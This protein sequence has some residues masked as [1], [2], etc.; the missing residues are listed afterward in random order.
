MQYKASDQDLKFI[1]A[2]LIGV[3]IAFLYFFI[4]LRK[5][6]GKRIMAEDAIVSVRD[7]SY[8]DFMMQLPNF[9]EDY[10]RNNPGISEK[11]RLEWLHS[12]E[13]TDSQGSYS[14]ERKEQFISNYMASARVSG[15]NMYVDQK[16]PL[17]AAS[18]NIINPR[19]SGAFSGDMY[20][21]NFV[22][23]PPMNY[24]PPPAS[25]FAGPSSNYVPPPSSY[26]QKP[27]NY[28]PQPSNYAPPPSNYVPAPNNYALAPNTYAPSPINYAAPGNYPPGNYP[29]GNYPPG[30]YPPGNY[31]PGNYPPGNYPPGNYPPGNYP[32]GN[33]PPANYPPGNYPPGNYPPGNYP[34]SN[35]Y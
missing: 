34:P 16:A 7:S 33:Y 4:P 21:R 35:P 25:N 3:I 8:D 11:Q 26:A 29:P 9:T 32:P 10:M 22:N 1:I 17:E 24:A 27:S 18:Y 20:S 15:I 19:A 23:E 14:R 5:I 2:P 12:V 30:N 6:C 28:A 13:L 31:P